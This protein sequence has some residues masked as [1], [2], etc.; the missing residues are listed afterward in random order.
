MIIDSH[1]HLPAEGWSVVTT[2]FPT[3]SEAIGYLREAGTDAAL[4][5]TWQGVFAE[6]A[7]DLV[8]ANAAAWDLAQEFEGFLYPGASIHP[9]FPKVSQEEL[10][11][12][13]DS[14]Y[15]WVGELVHY[16]K[17]YRYVDPE[18][19]DL[20][21]TC[22]KHGHILQL[23]VH[24]NIIEVARRFPA[25]PV[26]CSHID[27]ALCPRLAAEPNIWLDISGSGG[28]LNIGYLEAACQIFGPDRLLYGTDFTGYEPRAFQARVNTVMK[29]PTHREKIFWQNTVRLLEKVGSRPLKVHS[30]Q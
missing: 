17:P 4:F 28:G 14:G 30:P 5:N 27:L 7:D 16:H 24:E 15:L 2:P 19:L 8:Q 11:R 13:R 3:V 26:V 23:H 20:C 6:T 29:D 10:A 9:A 21:E 25:M 12:F 22:A 1:T 18:F